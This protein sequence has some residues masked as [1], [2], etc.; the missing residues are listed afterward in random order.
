MPIQQCQSSNAS[1]VKAMFCTCVTAIFGFAIIALSNID[2]TSM[3]GLLTRSLSPGLTR[4]SDASTYNLSNYLA[5]SLLPHTY[6]QALAIGLRPL[7]PSNKRVSASAQKHKVDMDQ[8]RYGT[9]P[10]MIFMYRVGTA[11][12]CEHNDKRGQHDELEE[13]S[14]ARRRRSRLRG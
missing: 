7:A 9:S 13:H 1:V 8:G 3:E 10:H 5:S 6:P 2:P 12:T 4:R 14:C 11:R